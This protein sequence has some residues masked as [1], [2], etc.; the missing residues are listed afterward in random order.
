MLCKFF[1]HNLQAGNIDQTEWFATPSVSTEGSQDQE[2]GFWYNS[3][4][5]KILDV[6]D[7]LVNSGQGE[8]LEEAVVE[9]MRNALLVMNGEG[10]LVD[11]DGEKRKVWEGTWSRIERF[12]PAL[13]SDMGLDRPKV[14]E[15]P[16]EA[17]VPQESAAEEKRDVVVNV[18]KTTEG[19][20]AVESVPV[21]K[22][23]AGKDD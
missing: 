12:S 8:N 14:M 11:E 15:Q 4:W 2:V 16:V 10:Y 17:P 6:L 13:R 18:L 9:L 20:S 22:Q 23:Y 21:K 5:C 19:E 1:L 7:R 3:V